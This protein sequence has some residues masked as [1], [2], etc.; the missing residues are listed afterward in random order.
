MIFIEGGIH[1]REWIS[2]ATVTFFIN[3]LLTSNNSRIQ[4]IAQN[5]DW[6]IFPIFNPDGYD[7]SWKSNRLWRK[8]RSCSRRVYGIC[9]CYGVDPNRNWNVSWTYTDNPCDDV[10]PGK[11]PFSEIET[12]SLSS[13]MSALNISL[14]L[15]FHAYG[16]IL[17]YP[18]GFKS[19]EPTNNDDYLIITNVTIKALAEKFGTKYVGGTLYEA[20]GRSLGNSLDWNVVK[21]NVPLGFGYELRPE[22]TNTGINYFSFILPANQ[23]VPTGLETTDSLVALVEE[24]NSLGYL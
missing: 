9:V 12:K 24:A 23:I 10:Y 20:V 7:Y 3:E 17:L 5:Y 13:Y 6:Y 8:T 19:E 21:N 4:R 22:M 2:P 16:Q 11:V 1:A 18:Y 15:A 14:Y